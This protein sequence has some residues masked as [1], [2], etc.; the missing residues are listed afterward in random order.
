MYDQKA[1]ILQKL[2]ADRVYQCIK[3][4]TNKHTHCVKAGFS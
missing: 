3:T 4:H 2:L 1:K